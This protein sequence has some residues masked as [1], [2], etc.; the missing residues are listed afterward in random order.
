VSAPATDPATPQATPPNPPATADAAALAAEVARLRGKNEELLAEKKRLAGRLADL[1]EDVDPRQLWADRQAAE[2]RRLEAEGNYIQAR[3]QLE[4]QYR[5]SEAG[6]KTRIAEL[7]AEI[8]QLKVLGPAATALSEHV[9]GADEVVKYNLRADQLATE[10]DGSVVVV[11]G[12]NRTPLAE[13]ARA[14]L[15]QWRLKAPK[16]AGT[17]APPG[18]SSAGGGDG[19]LPPGANPWQEGNLTQQIELANRDP[20][21]A[22]RLAQAAGKRLVIRGQ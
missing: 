4:Q 18:G 8:R 9:H 6:L 15:P 16:P 14:T 21:L 20:Q 12:Y 2:T 13:W 10:A 1:P 11:D 5:D 7:E 19:A 3:E 22:M 17:G